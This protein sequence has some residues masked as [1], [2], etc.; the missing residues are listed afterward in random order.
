MENV[1]YHMKIADYTEKEGEPPPR[2]PLDDFREKYF[3]ACF[4]HPSVD[5]DFLN[6]QSKTKPVK[7][8]AESDDEDDEGEAEEKGAPPAITNGEEKKDG[9]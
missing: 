9:G 6:A 7:K 5:L 4:G 2:S 3:S 1:A 8:K